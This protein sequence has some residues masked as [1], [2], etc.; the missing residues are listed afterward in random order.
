[1]TGEEWRKGRGDW[2]RDKGRLMVMVAWRDPRGGLRVM[3]PR[4]HLASDVRMEWKEERGREGTIRN[5][6]T[7][8]SE[9][10]IL[11]KK[12]RIG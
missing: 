4:T 9:L 6:P 3:L 11:Q 1:M 10:E 8:V 5:A 12:I 7:K 2:R